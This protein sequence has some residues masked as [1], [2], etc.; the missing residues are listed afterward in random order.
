VNVKRSME[1]F[2]WV[3]G[4]LRR[5]TQYRWYWFGKSHSRNG[6]CRIVWNGCTRNYSVGYLLL[7]H[8]SI[9]RRVFCEHDVKEVI[10]K[11]AQAESPISRVLLE[12][13][14]TSGSLC[15]EMNSL[16][17]YCCCWTG[18]HSNSAERSCERRN[19]GK[20][21]HICDES[22]RDRN[23]SYMAHIGGCI[24]DKSNGASKHTRTALKLSRAVCA[25]TDLSSLMKNV[26]PQAKDLYDARQRRVYLKFLVIQAVLWA[27]INSIKSFFRNVKIVSSSTTVT[28]S[29]LDGVRNLKHKIECRVFE[30]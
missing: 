18:W 25:A 11:S 28:A 22:R 6:R 8:A 29:I 10:T 2:Y 13:S 26:V 3:T 20:A 15:G 1:Y 14:N 4:F 19:Y 30:H 23:D 5:W 17:V 21:T 12:A 9:Y 27:W 24:N 7:Y 16:W